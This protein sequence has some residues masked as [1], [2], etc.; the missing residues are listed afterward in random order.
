MCGVTTQT[1]ADSPASLA[2]VV[3]ILEGAWRADTAW[4]D[5]WD[6][7][8]PARGQ[9]GS[10]ALVVQDLCGGALMRGL[11]EE[12]PGDLIVHYWNALELGEFDSTWQQFA[13]GARV[14]SSTQVER[15]HL[16]TTTWLTE[17][18]EA[19]RDRV[20]LGSRPR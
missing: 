8:N 9:C 10:S 12:S 11:V 6:P 16:L 18:Y 15:E 14:V 13:D 19:L 20:R 2:H 4:I 5:D 1:D 17:R 7:T 3:T